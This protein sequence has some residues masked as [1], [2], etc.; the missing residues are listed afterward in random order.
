MQ[1]R[2]AVGSGASIRK[3]ERRW[4]ITPR[5]GHSATDSPDEVAS[6]F[7]AAQTSPRQLGL[8]IAA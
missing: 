2:F 8:P 1:R 7:G 5:C 3:A 4:R 6:L